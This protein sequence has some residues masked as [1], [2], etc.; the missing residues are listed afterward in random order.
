M[1]QDRHERDML[2][3]LDAKLEDTGVELAGV[4]VKE[5]LSVFIPQGKY[6]QDETL[7]A[8]YHRCWTKSRSHLE[9]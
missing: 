1:G 9:F 4:H 3:D 7:M 2:S 8:L 5:M 6:Y